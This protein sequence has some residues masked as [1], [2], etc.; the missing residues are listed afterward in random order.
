MWDI[1]AWIIVGGAVGVLATLL[2]EGAN[3]G[4]VMDIFIGVVGASFGGALLTLLAP[5]TFEVD[6]FNLASLIVALLG[7]VILLALIRVLTSPRRRAV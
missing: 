6:G 7:A 2:I 3:M 1:L 4:V 5:S